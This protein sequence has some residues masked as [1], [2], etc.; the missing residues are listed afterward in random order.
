M[1]E[2]VYDAGEMGI[3]GIVLG[4]SGYSAAELLRL[5]ANHPAFEVVALGAERAAGTPVESTQPHLAGLDLPPLVR[6]EEALAS[7]AEVVFS[8]LP[9]DASANDRL[10]AEGRVVVDLSDAHR[11]DPGWV[12]GLTEFA[13]K[14]LSGFSEEEN[15][16]PAAAR[17]ANPG[18][19]PTAALLALVPFARA[20]A[21]QGSI[22]IDAMSGF[23]GAG[24]SKGDAFS[25][26]SAHADVSS[27][28]S[29]EHRHI[30]EMER[31]LKVF[32]GLE[33]T[34]SFTPHLVPMSRGLL[35]TARAKVKTHLDDASALRILKDAYEGEPFV[36]VIDEWPHTKAVTGS[37][38]ACVSAR[39]DR[40]AGLLI[41]S[42]AIDNLGKGAAGQ[43]IQN[44]NLIFGLDET[45]GLARSGVWP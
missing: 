21:I 39:V 26:A 6:T 45:L 3:H 2:V 13:R 44:A 43:A 16:S 5:A 34:V 4:A 7:E 37:N 18:C 27:Y 14:S 20:G 28:G 32:S 17:V 38:L 15:P 36:Q 12:Y 10:D 30:A 42:A 22:S 24:R 23:S 29:T 25:L 8:C 1:Q 9:G 40:R 31:H 41:C 11:A 35:V 19:Y 33:T